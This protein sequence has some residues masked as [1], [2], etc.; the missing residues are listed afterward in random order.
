MIRCAT[1]Q[2]LS[3][4]DWYAFRKVDRNISSRLCKSAITTY[5]YPDHKEQPL[6]LLGVMLSIRAWVEGSLEQ[7]LNWIFSKFKSFFWLND[8]SRGTN[9]ILDKGTQFLILKVV[10]SDEI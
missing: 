6:P 4:I 7:S 9:I 1:P 2:G 5:E 8:G 10:T 3:P